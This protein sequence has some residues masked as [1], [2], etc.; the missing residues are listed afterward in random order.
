MARELEK[1]KTRQDY[2]MEEKEVVIADNVKVTVTDTLELMFKRQ[3]FKYNTDLNEEI[4]L[5]KEKHSEF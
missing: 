5:I 2:R 4:N 3:F 1:F